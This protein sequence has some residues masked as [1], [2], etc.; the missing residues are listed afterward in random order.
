MKVG[1]LLGIVLTA[2]VAGFGFSN[3][4]VKPTTENIDLCK[5][6]SGNVEGVVGEV[7]GIQPGTLPS[8]VNVTLG[9]PASLCTVSINMTRGQINFNAGEVIKVDGIASPFG[10]TASS[11]TRNPSLAYGMDGSNGLDV[12][13]GIYSYRDVVRAEGM[14][15]GYNNPFNYKLPTTKGSVS[16]SQ[17]QIDV[18]NR[19][20]EPTKLRITINRNFEVVSIQQVN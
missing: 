17:S 5:L 12:V 6:P 10:V 19:Y 2:A 11:I 18:I 20:S 13:E 8:R 4:G 9:N 14:G 3:M 16:L 15:A 7:L 1:T